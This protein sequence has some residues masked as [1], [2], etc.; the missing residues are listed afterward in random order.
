MSSLNSI[1]E[2]FLKEE[3][4]IIYKPIYSRIFGSVNSGLL[5]ASLIY[6]SKIMK[7]REFYKTDKD[8]CEETG[9]MISALRNAKDKIVKSGVFKVEVKSLPARTFYKVDLEKL[10]KL[11]NKSKKPTKKI[12]SVGCC[13]SDKKQVSVGGVFLGSVEKLDVRND[14]PQYSGNGHAT[15]EIN[16]EINTNTNTKNKIN[17]NTNHLAREKPPIDLSVD[18]CSR[19]NISMKESNQL[20]IKEKS[21]IKRHIAKAGKMDGFE[22]FW[23]K[24]PR[25]VA[26]GDAAKAYLKA[27]EKTSLQSILV[28]LEAQKIERESFDRFNLWKPDWKHPAVWLN[29][30][31]WEDVPLMLDEIRK[32][33]QAEKLSKMSYR[34]VKK[35]ESKMDDDAF[36]ERMRKRAEKQGLV[37]KPS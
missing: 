21:K 2:E 3:P 24:Y 10:I 7:H 5:A 29:K 27:I 1:L 6:W 18:D 12:K 34:D 13:I 23:K 4:L 28:A 11:I 8:L 35:L 14:K 22:E 32:K 15:S 36:N 17:N 25:K 37:W 16:T 30:M 26:K 20:T 33:A 19:D 31:C 9:L